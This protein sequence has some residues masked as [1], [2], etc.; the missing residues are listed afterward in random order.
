[1][2]KEVKI[3]LAAQSF[4]QILG[5]LLNALDEEGISEVQGHMRPGGGID[6][7]FIGKAIFL[8]QFRLV[9]ASIEY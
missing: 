3:L 1:M 9:P 2:S 8:N 7:A 4:H 5:D 6:L